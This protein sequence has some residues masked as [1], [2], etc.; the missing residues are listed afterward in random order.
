MPAIM[1]AMQVKDTGEFHIIEK[2]A[3]AI[4]G[5]NAACI[6][7]LDET[8]FRLRLGI[9]DDAAAWDAPAGVRVLTTDT[10]VEGVH[11]NLGQINWRDLGWKALASNLSDV[12]AMGCTPLYSLITLGLRG[13]LP[14]DGLE[15]MYRGMAEVNRT[16][17]GAVVGG[18]I[19]RSPVFFVTVALEGTTTTAGGPLLTRSA[20]VV[21]D[22]VAVTGSLG[23]SAGGLR[24]LTEG[25]ELAGEPENH[26]R[27]VHNRPMPR[28]AEGLALV[29]SGVAAAI[30]IS[31]GLV[32]DLGKLCRSS[33]VG[34]LIRADR[35][36]AD[37]HLKLAFPDEWLGLALGGGEE[38]E[39][40]FAAPEEIMDWAIARLETPVTVIGEIV[41]GP[42]TVRVVDR[43]G[44]EIPVDS[45]GWDHFQLD[46]SSS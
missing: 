38:Y 25:L 16:C 41:T 22:R 32:D 7:R 11:F 33:G 28:V 19:V 20:A 43:N 8:G 31:D 30:D 2:L 15:E 40:L 27:M 37:N 3:G 26:L 23:C 9:G 44:I 6:A 34:A 46:R 10:M 39:L 35:V 21:G 4:A 5:D 14:V 12:A 29:G 1:R 18:D 13:D 45:G 24:M 17:G 36:P 42:A